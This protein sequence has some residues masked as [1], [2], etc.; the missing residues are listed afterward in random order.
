MTKVDEK[1]ARWF[2]LPAIHEPTGQVH[3]QGDRDRQGP[4]KS[5][6]YEL[7]VTICRRLTEAAQHTVAR[8][9]G[10][11]FLPRLCGRRGEGGSRRAAAPF[12]RREAADLSPQRPGR[13]KTC[14]LAAAKT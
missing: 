14:A 9:A 6:T 2:A 11:L 1:D 7:P 10:V 5:A 8:A 12:T 13:G 3:R 4:K